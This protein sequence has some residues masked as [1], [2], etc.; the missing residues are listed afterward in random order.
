M[1]L[2]CQTDHDRPDHA[3]VSV[4]NELTNQIRIRIDQE[5]ELCKVVVNQVKWDLINSG[6]VPKVKKLLRK[7]TKWS[8]WLGTFIDSEAGFYIIPDQRIDKIIST[9][10]DIRTCLATRKTVNV[11]KFA[12]LVGQN[13]IY[14]F[15]Y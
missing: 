14:I 12:S 4:M 15:S 8:I 11:K 10:N 7:P 5:D 6:F 1:Y 3:T 2:L 9:I 13:N